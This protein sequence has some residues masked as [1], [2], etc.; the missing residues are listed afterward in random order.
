[1]SLVQSI[2]SIRVNSIMEPV[3]TSLYYGTSQLFNTLYNLVQSIFSIKVNL[4]NS[5]PDLPMTPVMEGFVILKKN[6]DFEQT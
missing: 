5:I 4:L 1:M 2:F 3:S 6:P